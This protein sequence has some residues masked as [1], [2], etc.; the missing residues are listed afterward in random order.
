MVEPEIGRDQ[1]SQGSRLGALSCCRHRERRDLFTLGDERSL[2]DGRAF[3][4]DLDARLAM[5]ATLLTVTVLENLEATDT[6]IG[7]QRRPTISSWL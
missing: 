2:S 6:D 3:Q 7:H 4:I 1:S 5:V